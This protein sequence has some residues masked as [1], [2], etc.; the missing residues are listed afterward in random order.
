M[1]STEGLLNKF[2]E[3]WKKKRPR[4]ALTAQQ[5]QKAATSG[6]TT[7]ANRTVP[8]RRGPFNVTGA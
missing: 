6:A 5:L 8:R 4:S 3:K 2:F 1:A 7:Y